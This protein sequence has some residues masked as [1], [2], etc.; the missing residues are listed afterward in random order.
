MA[1]I[2]GL[3]HAIDDDAIDT[4]ASRDIILAASCCVVMLNVSRT[5]VMKCED[6]VGSPLSF[7][8]YV[9]DV[10]LGRLNQISYAVRTN[11]HI[12]NAKRTRVLEGISDIA[13]LNVCWRG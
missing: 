1:K 3:C 5:D 8:S 4:T 6:I 7:F 2:K 10:L 11:E 9:T 12:A 13:M